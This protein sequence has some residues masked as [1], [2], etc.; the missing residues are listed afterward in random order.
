MFRFGPVVDL[1]RYLHFPRDDGW[2][3]SPKHEL[4]F[5]KQSL[6]FLKN[7]QNL[8]LT[9]WVVEPNI[10][11]SSL[12][13][14]TLK[15]CGLK[16][17]FC[18]AGL[19]MALKELSC[20]ISLTVGPDESRLV[21]LFKKL[22]VPNWRFDFDVLFA[23]VDDDTEVLNCSF[24]SLNDE[25]CLRLRS[26]CPNL[27]QGTMRVPSLNLVGAS[28][29]QN[30]SEIVLSTFASA[31]A[32]LSTD[33]FSLRFDALAIDQLTQLPASTTSLSL[34]L[35]EGPQLLSNALPPQFCDR[36]LRSSIFLDVFGTL[37]DRRLAHVAI[38]AARDAAKF[39]IV[40]GAS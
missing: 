38:C 15:D 12:T 29:P 3:L 19:P 18:L 34:A 23:I 31:A 32:S 27:R 6:L 39:E 13:A 2:D 17:P 30:V 8:T 24:Y 33:N 11:P 9:E 14:L 28:L 4:S 26:R 1:P 40:A 7:V 36:N 25:Q 10:W 16:P 5:V 21:P 35:D 20:D 22:E 37:P